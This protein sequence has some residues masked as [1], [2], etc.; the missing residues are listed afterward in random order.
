M[1]EDEA[2][3]FPTL[4]SIFFYNAYWEQL[5]DTTII[6]ILSGFEHLMKYDD[7]IIFDKGSIVEQGSPINLLK[8]ENS[9]LYSFIKEADKALF[10]DLQKVLKSMHSENL[11]SRG[12]LK[13]L[14]HLKFI[15]GLTFGKKNGETN[16]KL[17]RGGTSIAENL[18]IETNA[19]DPVSDLNS[20]STYSLKKTPTIEINSN[21]NKLGNGPQPS[22]NS[23]EE[24][25]KNAF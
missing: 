8:N 22:Q 24:A 16:T 9:Y 14:Q 7:V 12:H 4:D 3:N 25:I 21:S 18:D 13:T 2:F 17:T 1:I 5:R 15:Q 10:D 6:S 23:K 11:S 20:R 19:R